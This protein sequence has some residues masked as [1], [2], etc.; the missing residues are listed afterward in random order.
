MPYCNCPGLCKG[1]KDV[2]DRTYRSHA[3]YRI[4]RLSDAFNNFIAA[5]ATRQPD[6]GPGVHTTRATP[7]RQQQPNIATDIVMEEQEMADPDHDRA[8][9]IFDAAADIDLELDVRP[10]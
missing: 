5:E 7:A 1:G 2:S 4:P 8:E 6:R 9:G 3:P 10:I